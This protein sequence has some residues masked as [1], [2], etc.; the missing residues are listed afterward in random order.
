MAGDQQLDR[1]RDLGARDADV[2]EQ[3]VGQALQV[4]GGGAS[5]SGAAGVWRARGERRTS[6]PAGGSGMR[7]RHA[8]GLSGDRSNMSS[9]NVWT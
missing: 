3:V 4:G 5:P 9:S 7:W 8:I 6:R 1:P 2:V